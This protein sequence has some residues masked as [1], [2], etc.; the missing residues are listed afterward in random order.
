MIAL[1]VGLLGFLMTFGSL[2]QGA[3]TGAIIGTNSISKFLGIFGIFLMFIAVVIERYE[4]K[5]KK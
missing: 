5:N 2:A 3:I 4:L 1:L